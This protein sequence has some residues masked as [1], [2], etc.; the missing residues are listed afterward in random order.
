MPSP[1]VIR[2]TFTKEAAIFP[3]LNT[4]F[5]NKPLAPANMIWYKNHSIQCLNRCIIKAKMR[6][7]LQEEI[8][9]VGVIGFKFRDPKNYYS[10]V[11]KKKYIE[12]KN[13]DS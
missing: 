10:L 6:F 12:D 7:P 1:W 9:Q 5:A 13:S 11:I 3:Q 2:D 8:L 4:E